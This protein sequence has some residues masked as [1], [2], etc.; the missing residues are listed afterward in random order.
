MPTVEKPRSLKPCSKSGRVSS[1]HTSPTTTTAVRP[2]AMNPFGWRWQTLPM[3]TNAPRAVVRMRSPR[4]AGNAMVAYSP[5]PMLAMMPTTTAQSHAGPYRITTSRSGMATAA[6]ASLARSTEPF[7]VRRLND[8]AEAALALLI[9]LQCL[10]EVWLAKIWPQ[11]IGEVDLGVRALPEEE[12]GDA[13]LTAGA[14]QQVG[15]GNTGRGQIRGQRLLV[16]GVRIDT[17]GADVAR[18]GARR[19]REIFAPAVADGEH[20][21][22][23]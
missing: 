21:G 6:V 8:A 9:D 14:N 5:M 11:G 19:L 2:A 1:V 22:H 17:S 16:D 15:V 4:R 10:D 18:Q 23:A 13:H 20:H 12:V 7:P 3:M